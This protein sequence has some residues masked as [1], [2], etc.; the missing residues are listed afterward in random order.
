MQYILKKNRVYR[1]LSNLSMLFVYV[2]RI[3]DEGTVLFI[4]L[5]S[6]CPILNS[7]DV[8]Y[9][10]SDLYYLKREYCETVRSISTVFE[11]TV[12]EKVILP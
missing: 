1:A 9:K 5:D 11:F 10:L 12:I 8:V 2:E 6:E 4:E 3:D 7:N